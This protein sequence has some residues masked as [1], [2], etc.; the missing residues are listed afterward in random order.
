MDNNLPTERPSM[1]H[2]A[3]TSPREYLGILDET[4][5]MEKG[6]KNKT[7]TPRKSRLNLFRMQT[8]R[9]PTK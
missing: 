7:I 8:C 9:V 6:L 5:L 2:K 3:I 1:N 4:K